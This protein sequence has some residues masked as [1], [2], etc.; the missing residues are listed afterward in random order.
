MPWKPN[1]HPLYKQY[2]RYAAAGFILLG[3]GYM[4]RS[5][6]SID[7]FPLIQLLSIWPN[8]LGS[9][10]APFAIQLLLF[11]YLQDSSVLSSLRHFALANLI[12]FAGVLIIEFTQVILRLGVWDQYDIT[13]SILSG[14]AAA[15][16]F[17]A[18][19]RSLRLRKYYATGKYRIP[20]RD[21]RRIS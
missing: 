19:T 13:A 3:I 11:E 18:T 4:L 8:L 20:R 1:P 5:F 7:F 2:Y 17:L 21:Q 9:F 14:T 12:T 16:L 10:A 6:I 15:A